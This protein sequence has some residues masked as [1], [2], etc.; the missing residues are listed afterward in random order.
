[1][2][3]LIKPIFTDGTKAR[4]HFAAIRG[5]HGPICSHCGVV[6][7]TTL[8]Q[9]ESRRTDLDQCNACREPFAVAAGTVMESSKIPLSKRS[10]AFHVRAAG[11]LEN[12][13][14]Q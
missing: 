6:D 14:S 12:D 1:M 9:S 5:P 2:T 11:H 8:F 4:R 10:L 13:V 7:Q 3:S